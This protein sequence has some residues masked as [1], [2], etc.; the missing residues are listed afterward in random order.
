MSLSLNVGKGQCNVRLGPGAVCA[1]ARNRLRACKARTA[2]N[3]ASELLLLA[4]SIN[5][6]TAGACG[7]RLG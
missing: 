3:A 4:T 1:P 7:A 2:D 6:W 5:A